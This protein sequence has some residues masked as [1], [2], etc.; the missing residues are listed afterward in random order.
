MPFDSSVTISKSSFLNGI[1][2]PKLLWTKFHDRDAFPPVDAQQQAIFDQGHLIGD[3]AKSLFPG[4]IEVAEGVIDYEETQ[5]AT[6]L[7]LPER[8]PLF[9]AAFSYNGGFV[10]V[11][12][13]NPVGADAWEIIEVKSST[14]VKDENLQ[15]IAFQRYVCEGAGLEITRCCLMHVNN[16]YVR[17][18]DIV[19]GELLPM[20]DVT[21]EIADLVIEVP[22]GL[23][24]LKRVVSSGD[25]PE[26]A[27]GPH[28]N[29][30][31]ECDLKYRCWAFLPKY[32]V[33][34]LYRDNRG[35]RW[36]LLESGIHGI[37]EIPEGTPGLNAKHEI[38]RRTAIIGK[39]HID[40]HAIATFLAGVHWPLTYFD[41]ESFQRAV[42]PY[43]DM[44][45]YR[46]IP[47][48][49]SVHVQPAPGADLDHH[50]FLA[51]S[52]EDPRQDFMEA[53]QQVIPDRG[54]IVAYNASFEK[55]ILKACAEAF[56]RFQPWVDSLLPRFVDLLIP[57]RNFSYHHPDQNGSASIKA[58]LPVLTET[59]Y[60]DLAIN[61]GGAASLAFV[62]MVFDQE[63][64][65]VRKA[66][67]RA[68]LLEYCALDTQAM[69][70]IVEALTGIV[71]SWT[72]NDRST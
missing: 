53:L 32:P 11:D 6:Q 57:F 19:P 4:G 65:D 71:E 70:D 48:Q 5:K 47:F 42:P 36:Q 63:T 10:R 21:D 66:E 15:D 52:P 14:R 39:P 59:S 20:E 62:E 26:I 22:A 23:E 40:H 41:L 67:I 13:L 46:Q 60:A 72:R 16:E 18:G 68:N 50:E 33:T 28:C 49:Y 44:R 64:T 56:P 9:E 7:L 25:C 51:S 31:Y 27:I 69:V 38:Q 2:C 37:A 55:G 12:V 1:Q 24:E 30:P 17:S 43:D 45:P 54:S 8:K 29:S 61:E 58:V 3:L 35:V 34:D